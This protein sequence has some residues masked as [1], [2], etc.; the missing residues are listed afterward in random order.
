M[1]AATSSAAGTEAMHA[2]HE[3]PP[4][5][6]VCTRWWNRDRSVLDPRERE[7]ERERV[8]TRARQQRVPPCLHMYSAALVAIYIPAFLSHLKLF[9]LIFGGKEKQ[10]KIIF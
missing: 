7:I 4:D 1:T 9:I 2:G 10:P 3:T 6:M 8:V 5:S